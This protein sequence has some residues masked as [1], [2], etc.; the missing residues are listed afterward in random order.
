ME[1]SPVN[2]FCH[3]VDLPAQIGDLNRHLCSPSQRIESS[4]RMLNFF[5]YFLPSSRCG[6]ERE[7]LPCKLPPVLRNLL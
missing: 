7:N 4:N 1:N 6:F 2:M 5:K 3:P